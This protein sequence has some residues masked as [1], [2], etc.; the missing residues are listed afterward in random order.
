[1]A[2]PRTLGPIIQVAA[3]NARRRAM[4][5]VAELVGPTTGAGSY[6]VYVDVVRREVIA[7]GNTSLGIA[8]TWTT[9]AGLTN[10]VG[11]VRFSGKWVIEETGVELEIRQH[12]RIVMLADLP[13]GGAGAAN[14]LLLTDRLRFADNVYG[15]S[16]WRVMEI[17]V[18][19]SDRLCWALCE[20]AREEDDT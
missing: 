6:P 13:A 10:L 11:H 7:A 19:T 14:A 17:R 8:P 12:Q 3:Q 4:V 15:T 20:W 16:V 1:M 18:R 9:V 2:I 5:A